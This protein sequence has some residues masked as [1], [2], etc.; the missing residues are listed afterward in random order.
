MSLGF[1][2]LRCTGQ[3]C[4]LLTFFPLFSAF[5]GLPRPYV[6]QPW[7]LCKRRMSLFYWLGRSQLWNSTSYMSRAVLRTWDFYSGH[8]NVQLWSQVDRIWLL[9]RYSRVCFC[10]FLNYQVLI[11]VCLNVISLRV[12]SP[13]RHRS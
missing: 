12:W 5:R 11:A 3:A 8:W 6:F 2:I 10:L 7:H 4:S 1:I 9:N 13:C